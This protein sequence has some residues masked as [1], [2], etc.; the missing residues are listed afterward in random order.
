M[1]G[2]K[3][4]GQ[5]ERALARFE[6]GDVMTLVATD[7]AARGIDVADIERVINFDAPADRDTYVHRIG[8]TGRAGRTGAGI[9]F[10]LAD[11]AE[12]MRRIA[13]G[14]GLT[15]EFGSGPAPPADAEGETPDPRRPRR[16]RRR[17]RGRP[18]VGA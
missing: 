12:E 13:S 4:Q 5:R 3:T 1:H 2:D 11:Q 14:L 16:R 10:V 8:R 18:R 15:E 7:V 6:R 17:R 9:S